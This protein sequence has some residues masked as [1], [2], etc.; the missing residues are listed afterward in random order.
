MALVVSGAGDPSEEDQAA[1]A[2]RGFADAFFGRVVAGIVGCLRPRSVHPVLMS[3]ESAAARE[4]ALTYLRQGRADG[5]LVVSSHATTR[6]P[7]SPPKRRCPPSCSPVPPAPSRSAMSIWL[8]GT[9]AGSPP[10][11]CSPAGAGGRPPS[12]VRSRSP[13]ARSGWPVSGTPSPGVAMPRVLVAEGGFTY[14][15]GLVAMAVL[16]AEHPDVGGVFAVNDL[17]A[18][19][20]ETARLLDE[21]IHRTRTEPTSVVSGPELVVRESA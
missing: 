17:M 20:A 11:T 9:A 6:C 1:F 18:R 12:P 8:T 7:R 19:G 2:A 21:H 14:V 10:N 3:A 16:L 13:P 5:A 15:S 4:E